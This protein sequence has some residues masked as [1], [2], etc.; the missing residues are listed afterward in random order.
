MLGADILIE[1]AVEGGD[2]DG[3]FFLYGDASRL[4]DQAARRLIDAA[5]D[6][7][8]ADFN[9]DAFRGSEADPEALASALA[10]PPIMAPRRVVALYDIQ[11]AG[12]KARGVV[13][14]VLARMPPELCFIV[15]ARIPDRSRAKLYQNLKKHST[16]AEWTAPRESELPGW[17]M[18]R[19][20]QRYDFG[21]EPAA[22]QALAAAVGADLALLDVELEK[23]S[24]LGRDT[25]DRTTVEQVVPNVRRVDRWVWLDR[26]A[27]REYPEALRELP[28]LI[29]EPRESAVGLLIPMVDQHILIGIAIEGGERAVSTAL[30]A[31]G[32]PYLAWKARTYAAQARQ[33]SPGRLQRALDCMLQADLRAKSSAGDLAVIQALLLTLAGDDAR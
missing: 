9:F 19:A 12:T 16:S 10:S 13:E 20:R 2:L 23:L 29:T 17:L 27:N 18:E 24:D 6:P 25:V 32:K 5:L 33:W 30:K 4:K 14:S 8:T 22:A 21:L 7:A 3:A 26:V 1:K 15:T 11:D 31:A 28:S